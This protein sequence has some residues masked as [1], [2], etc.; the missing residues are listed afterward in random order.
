MSQ[1]VG[2]LIIIV[3]VCLFRGFFAQRF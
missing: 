3:C 1:S 2:Q